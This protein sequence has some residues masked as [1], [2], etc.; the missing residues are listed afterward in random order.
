LTDAA[1]STD[2][3]QRDKRRQTNAFWSGV[4]R[5]GQSWE[6]IWDMGCGIGIGLGFGF[7]IGFGSGYG[8]SP[9]IVIVIPLM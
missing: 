1:A 2:N 6:W 8:Q 3:E 4:D 9:N 7:G 5:T